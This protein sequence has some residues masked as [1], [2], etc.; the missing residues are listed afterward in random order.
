LEFDTGPFEKKDAEPLT[1][2]INRESAF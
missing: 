2:E 1:L